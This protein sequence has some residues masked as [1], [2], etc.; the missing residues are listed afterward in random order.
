DGAGIAS[1]ADDILEI[2]GI[3]KRK[4][5]GVRTLL[6]PDT[7]ELP[8]EERT[9][10]ALLDFSPTSISYLQEKT[11]LEIPILTQLL[12][13][14]ELKGFVERTGPAHYIKKIR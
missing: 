2:L 9:L 11:K 4:K 3:V 12:L 8:E 14:L 6:N 1:T 5:K 13:S 10:M 7:K